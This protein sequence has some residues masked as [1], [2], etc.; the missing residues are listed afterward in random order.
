MAPRAVRPRCTGW[1]HQ[2]RAR[3]GAQAVHSRR[4]PVPPTGSM[5]RLAASARG[6]SGNFAHTGP[7]RRHAR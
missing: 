4:A 1:A 5:D 2:R 7:R 6:Y 3:H